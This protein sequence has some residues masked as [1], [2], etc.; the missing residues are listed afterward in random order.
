MRN[1]NF[2]VQLWMDANKAGF[3]YIE[4]YGKVLESVE[5]DTDLAGE[6]QYYNN[7]FIA[8]YSYTTYENDFNLFAEMV[9]T[10]PD[11]LKEL[12]NKYPLIKKKYLIVKDFYL[13][14]SP[15]FADTFSKIL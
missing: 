1:Y 8:K 5:N 14:I 9:F 12:V 7:G 15:V 13:S 6:E 4:D 11:R 10:E 2:P 3:K